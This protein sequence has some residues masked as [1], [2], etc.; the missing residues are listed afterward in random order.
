MQM[1][2]EVGHVGANGGGVAEQS[3][4]E[5]EEQWAAALRHCSSRSR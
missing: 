4:E 3:G 1:G 5:S 2:F